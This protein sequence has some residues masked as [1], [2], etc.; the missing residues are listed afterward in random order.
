MQAKVDLYNIL[1]VPRTATPEELKRSFKILAME[2]HPDKT[3]GD[4]TKEEYFKQVTDA[5]SILS[6]P[7]KKEMYDKYGV[8][9]ENEMGHGGMP[10]GFEDIFQ[11]IFGGG[12]GMPMGGGGVSFMFG[13]GGGGD[14]PFDML[15]N[16][17]GGGGMRGNRGHAESIEKI[18][19][20]ISLKEVYYGTTKKVEFEIVDMC[21]KC[22]GCGA[23]DASSII[24]CMTCKGEGHVARQI[25]PFMM[26]MTTCE[27]CRG[28]GSTIKLG[29][30]CLSCRGSKTQYTKKTFELALPKGIPNGREV[31]MA[32][33]GSWNPSSKQYGHIV[34][35]FNY[36][37]PAHV[38]LDG[39][40]VLY[41]LD[42]TLS[43][44]L[45]GF[46]KD[47]DI[48][49]ETYRIV[50]HGYFKPTKSHIIAGMGMPDGGHRKHHGNW[51]INFNVVYE[52]TSRLSRYP[53]VFQKMLKIKAPSSTL[54]NP[55]MHLVEL[56]KPQ[57]TVPEPIAA[58]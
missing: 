13:G 38:S 28:N 56:N 15:G 10:P 39:S 53:D 55:A 32:H 52:D 25:N 34:F 4:K 37:I 49:G 9:S 18:D 35:R 30:E 40:D 20:P 6:D 1:K 58:M 50:S 7:K 33:K 8:V 44:L 2:Y 42:I 54:P 17:F 5:Y 21:Q 23:C 22:N 14:S 24:K 47:I 31:K 11:N 51:I 46:E 27:S 12:M 29:K 48:Y 16:M 43:D 57:H 19:V 26:S 3:K 36:S 41:K 45:C